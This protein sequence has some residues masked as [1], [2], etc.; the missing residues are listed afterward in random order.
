ARRLS[1]RPRSS[2]PGTRR[3][4]PESGEHDA[5][6][7]PGAS[8]HRSSRAHARRRNSPMRER[9]E[10]SSAGGSAIRATGSAS[11]VLAPTIDGDRID[12]RALL[13]ANLG[14]PF[15]DGN[16]VD[17]LRN[18]VEI[19]APMLD[20]IRNAEIEVDFLTYVYWTGAIACE[21]AETLA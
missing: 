15:T 14:V 19:F 12:W 1:P 11:R 5:D 8:A 3:A 13:E 6:R 18:G 21:F 16:R 7:Q 17:V 10:A 9:A 4:G 2:V 20:A